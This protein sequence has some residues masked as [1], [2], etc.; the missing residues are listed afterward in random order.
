MGPCEGLQS[1]EDYL[2]D[3]DEAGK[4][5]KG[6]IGVVGRSY[7]EKMQNASEDLKF[8]YPVGLEK[9]ERQHVNYNFSNQDYCRGYA[10]QSLFNNVTRRNMLPTLNTRKGINPCDY[11][12]PENN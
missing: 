8:E 6:K 7:K 5:L 10:C 12:C 1:E 9:E 11:E 2:K 4:I 3:I